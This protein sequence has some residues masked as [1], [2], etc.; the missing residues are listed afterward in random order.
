MKGFAKD[1]KALTS[2][3]FI[4]LMQEIDQNHS[5]GKYG[6]RNW[7]KYVRPDF[8]MRDG[9][10]FHI[11][12]D[13]KVFSSSDCKTTMYEEIMAYLKRERNE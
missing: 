11:K 5:F 8:D 2:A 4:Q 6:H 7:V 10:C 3:Q 12:L 1:E 13:D 9:K